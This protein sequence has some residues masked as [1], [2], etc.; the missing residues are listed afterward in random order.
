[1]SYEIERKFLVTETSFLEG[2]AGQECR[3]G[4]LPTAGAPSVRVRIIGEGAYLT[5]KGADSGLTRREFEYPIPLS[6]ARDMLALL[7]QQPLIEKTRYAVEFAG[8]TWDVDRFHG[9]N[10]GLCMAE[11]ELESET[12]AFETPP[13]IGAEVTGQPAYYNVNL[14]VHPFTQWPPPTP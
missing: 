11:V 7:C 4:Y 6:D 1:M 9:A 5:L 10:R 3:Q 12:Q 2:R 13:W 8:T 14:A